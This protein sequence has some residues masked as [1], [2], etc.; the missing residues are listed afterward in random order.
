MRNKLIV[1]EGIDGVGKSTL[2]KALPGLLTEKGMPAIRFEDIE[3]KAGGFNLLKPF[4]KEEASTEASFLFY[5]ASAIHKSALLKKLLERTSVVCDRYVYS[6]IA[7]HQEKGLNIEIDITK[8][9]I[10]R[11]DHF[12]LITLP[13]DIRRQRI[14]SRGGILTKEDAQ[15]KVVGSRPF[16][17]ENIIRMF[18]PMEIE[19]TGILEETLERL[20][21][22]ILK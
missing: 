12:F 20:T 3:N 1:F 8:L 7:H 9:P 4:I 14:E 21:T 16:T 17:F 18:N 6:T 2:S 13:E 22:E 19:N 5:L 11:P 10:L 15:V